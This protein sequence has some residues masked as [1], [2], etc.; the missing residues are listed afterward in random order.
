MNCPYC[1][2]HFGLIVANGAVVPELAPG[3]CEN[4]ASVFLVLR[5][6]P[7]QLREGEL[8]ALKKSPAWKFLQKAKEVINKYRK[9]Q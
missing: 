5:G 1:D 8:E 7:R 6:V 3:I 9:V 2:F 4:C